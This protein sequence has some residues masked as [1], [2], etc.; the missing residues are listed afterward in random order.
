MIRVTGLSKIY[1][2]GRV[3]VAALTDVTFQIKAGE[4]VAIMGPSGSGKSTLMNILGCLDLPT[5]GSYRLAGR[6]MSGLSHGE[7]AEIRN[8][9]LGFIFQSF[10][11]LPRLNAW[12]NVELPLVYAGLPPKERRERALALLALVGLADR[13]EHRPQELSGGEQQRIA[14]ARALANRPAVILADEPTGNLDT[15]AGRE[16]MKI[17]TALH[18]EGKTI[19]MITHDPEIAVFAGRVLYFRDGRLRRDLLTVDPATN[20]VLT[21]REL[22]DRLHG[23]EEEQP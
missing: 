2:T 7:L 18:Q 13:A 11:L 17:F 21:A 22:I 4:F 12:R 6:E 3:Q 9:E 8:R 14:I 10:N 20:A 1:Q 5:A 23:E 15:K 16:I 19:V